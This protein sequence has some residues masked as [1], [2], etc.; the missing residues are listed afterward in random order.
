MAE[1]YFNRNA[2]A[3]G[4]HE[5]HNGDAN[6]PYPPDL[7]NRVRIGSYSTCIT[8]IDAARSAYPGW[9]FDGCYYCTQCHTR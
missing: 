8:A 7:A 4:F 2:Q 1:Y 9:S 3:D 6:C 5:V